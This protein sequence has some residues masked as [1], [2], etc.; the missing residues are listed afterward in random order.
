M[1]RRKKPIEQS[2]SLFSEEES[3]C[4]PRE[5]GAREMIVAHVDSGARGN[6][7]PAGYGVFIT[8]A[9]GK[10]L[11]ELSEY[12]GHKTN[13]FAEYNGL[14]AALDFAVKHGHKRLQVVSDSE[15]MVKQ[16]NGAYKVRS[17]EL[18]D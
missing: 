12:L 11:G 6:P 14:L 2:S 1:H 3:P 17:P 10:M 7:G 9:Q 4:S 16:M 15:L 18:K 5:L 8:D 13:N